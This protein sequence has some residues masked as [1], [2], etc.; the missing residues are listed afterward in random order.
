MSS[1]QTMSGRVYA[2][3]GSAGG[4]GLAVAIGL[5]ARGAAVALADIKAEELQKAQQTIKEAHPEASLT[6]TVV[7]ITKRVQ[8]D[9]WILS[10]KEKFGKING[11]VNSAG[12]KSCIKPACS[13]PGTSGR[14]M[15]FC[16]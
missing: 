12:E 6:A 5:V 11:C 16:G 14:S 8:V 1:T 10:T 2:I 15:K 4:I 3:T 9:E 13:T 7:D